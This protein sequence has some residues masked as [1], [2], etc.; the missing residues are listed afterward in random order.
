MR[1]RVA[2]RKLNRTKEHRRALRRNMAQSLFEHGQ[3]TTT[4]VKAKDLRPWAEKM[5]TLARKAHQGALA[6][7]QRLMSLLGDR[8]IIPE[9]F[10]GEYEKMSDAARSRV[11]RYRSGRRHRTGQAKA[12]M[13]FTALSVSTR[14]Y[15]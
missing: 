6:A 7:R 13:K 5:I 3:I 10:R 12:G 14:I 2:R 15:Y 1:H 4:L 9:E 8:A 11:L